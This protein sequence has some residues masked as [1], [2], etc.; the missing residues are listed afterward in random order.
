MDITVKDIV[1]ALLK[2]IFH[3]PVLS[4]AFGFGSS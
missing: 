4:V 2:M 3:D 1:Y